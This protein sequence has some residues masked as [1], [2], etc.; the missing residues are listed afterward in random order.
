M[1]KPWRKDKFIQCVGR[2][3]NLVE[4]EQEMLQ[5]Q[6]SL[7]NLLNSESSEEGQVYSVWVETTLTTPCFIF[8]I[9]D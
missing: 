2:G 9:K 6:V 4:T 7:S 8:S 1:L 5:L 3:A